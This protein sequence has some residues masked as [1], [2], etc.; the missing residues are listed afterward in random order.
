[1]DGWGGVERRGRMEGETG[2]INVI[3][4]NRAYVNVDSRCS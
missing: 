3:T 1:M 4:D 2:E